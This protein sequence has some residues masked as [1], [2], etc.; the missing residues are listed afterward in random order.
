M[1]ILFIL[2]DQNGSF[3]YRIF[4]IARALRLLNYDVTITIS[5]ILKNK[6]SKCLDYDVII[7]QRYL[8]KDAAQELQYLRQHNK[9]IIFE[10]DDYYF[11]ICPDS[12]W[13]PDT[14]TNILLKEVL[15]YVDGVIVTTQ[16]LK[17]RYSQFNKNIL[18]F[19]NYYFENDL[20]FDIHK[21]DT[22]PIKICY[23]G[24]YNHKYDVVSIKNVVYYLMAKYKDKIEFNIFGGNYTDL[25][26]NKNIKYIGS[27]YKRQDSDFINNLK[28]INNG[29]LCGSVIE[30]Y[31]MLVDSK[32]DIALVPLTS[33]PHNDCK[34]DV[35]FLEYG[36]FK[37]PMIASNS[38]VY[39]N[40]Y[41]YKNGFIANNF[42]D[43]VEYIS[44]LI[45]DVELRNIITENAYK[46]V[47]NNYNIKD[48]INKYVEFLQR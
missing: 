19:N 17:D 31:Q 29:E 46:F 20:I 48:H 44:L 25:F 1:K 14:K 34:S 16:E 9:K 12:K 23:A 6:I 5:D 30:Y 18:I 26:Y 28:L 13:I 36:L 43:W 27:T 21:S 7:L 33:N 35:K 22:L 2:T 42:K 40:I 37:V 45:E 24:G 38:L 8:L 47:I 3:Y 39:N 10:I 15:R 11:E 41:N 4:N 32:I